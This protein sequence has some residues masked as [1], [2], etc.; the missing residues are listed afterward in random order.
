MK[1]LF[2]LILL[3]LSIFSCT[4][5]QAIDMDKNEILGTWNDGNMTFTFEKDSFKTCN[6]FGL[7]KGVY[8]IRENTIICKTEMNTY[9]YI[10]LQE[11]DWNN[12]KMFIYWFDINNKAINVLEKIK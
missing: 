12:K 9:L 3:S 4:K 7:F 5:K 6:E 2:F 11:T 10:Q 1:K 8:C